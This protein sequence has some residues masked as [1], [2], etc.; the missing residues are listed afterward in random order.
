MN[1]KDLVLDFNLYL[2]ERYGYKDSC[3]VSPTENGCCIC[4]RERD[5]KFYIRFWEYSNGVNA[6]PDW[7]VIIVSC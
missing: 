5:I 2:C 4:V 6:F 7:C 1:Q 3:H